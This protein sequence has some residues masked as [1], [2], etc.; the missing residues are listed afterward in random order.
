MLIRKCEERDLEKVMSIEKR[1]FDNPYPARIFKEYL[2]DEL[3]LV[4]EYEEVVG[5]II[6]EENE[7]HG[8]IVS[9][10]VFPSHRFEG[11]GAELMRSVEKKMEVDT[12]FVTVRPS[13]KGAIQFYEGL[14]FSKV[15]MIRDYYA[16]GEDGMVLKTEAE[17]KD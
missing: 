1:S 14:D 12:F 2:G 13:N 4:A 11:I 16:N 8:M 15:G 5:Y 7:V 3:F 9:I 10:A 17:G 6:G